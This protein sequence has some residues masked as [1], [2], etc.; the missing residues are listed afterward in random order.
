MPVFVVANPAALGGEIIL[1]PP[2]E[3]GFRRQRQLARFLVADQ[4]AA[5]G[6]HGFAALRPK[7]RDDVGRSRP[8]IEA[9]EDRLLDVESV[10]ERGDIRSKCGRLPVPER[11]RRKEARRAVPSQIGDDHPVS[12]R[13]KQR[14]DIDEAVD[15]VGPAVEEDDRR[16]AGGA[17]F[18]V[19]HVQQTGVD[20]LQRSER[21]LRSAGGS[22]GRSSPGEVGCSDGHGSRSQHAAAALVDGFSHG[23][24][25][26]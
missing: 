5:H 13:S 9:G 3:L 2:L 25:S 7:H 15:V 20:L 17:R 6:H 1:V 19:S 26:V 24:F 11:V 23:R 4:I 10:H 16:P 12:G 8:P 14:R 21:A 18:R 22:V